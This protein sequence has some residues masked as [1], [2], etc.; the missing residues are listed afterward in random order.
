MCVRVFQM[1]VMY[2][3]NFVEYN[4]VRG[5]ASSGI[6]AFLPH[7]DTQD[8]HTKRHVVQ[9]SDREAGEKAERQHNRK[10]IKQEVKKKNSWK[11]YCF[12]LLVHTLF[13]KKNCLNL[14]KK[15]FLSLNAEMP[16]HSQY[17]KSLQCLAS[18]SLNLCSLNC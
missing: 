18:K 16:F 13:F 9:Q 15:C 10:A 11:S 7:T 12:S 3:L 1:L 6:D 4:H 14:H 5:N 17:P 2:C 8:W